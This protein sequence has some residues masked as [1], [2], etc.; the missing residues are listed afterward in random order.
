MNTY[1]AK[2]TIYEGEHT[3][4]AVFLVQ[5]SSHDEAFELAK[6][7]EHEPIIPDD[8]DFPTYWN[9]GDGTTAAE[10]N[11]VIEILPETAKDL[12]ELGLAYYFEYRPRKRVKCVNNNTFEDCLT[13]GKSYEVEV[14]K[15]GGGQGM[16]MYYLLD[17]HKAP[18]NT[19]SWRFE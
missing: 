15:D 11:E 1:L 17:D 7:Q 18:L 14:E 19:L 6:S 16:D 10:L 2:F 5:A 13:V 4:R 9:Y 8:G 3:Y 12:E